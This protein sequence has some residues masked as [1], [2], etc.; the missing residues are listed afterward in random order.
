MTFPLYRRP[1]GVVFLDDD[2][3]YLEMLAMVMP[4]HW[5]LELFV[6]PQDCINRMQREPPLWEADA[7]LQQ[8]IVN[9]WREGQS[10]IPQLLAYWN[11]NPS[12]FGL[13]HV[14]VVDYSMPGLNGLQVLGELV[15]WP[16]TRVLLTGRA[17]E[18]IAVNA[19]NH[20]L[21]EQFIA[22]QTYDITRRLGEV[23]Q[24]LL[25]L[26]YARHSNIWRSTL[27]PEQDA[28]LR[29]PSVSRDLTQL[30]QDQG[31]IEHVV[32]GNPFGVLALNSS[33]AASWLQLERSDNLGEL[34]EL[35]ESQGVPAATVAQIRAGEKLVNMELKL[36]LQIEG[37]PDV[38]PAFAMGPDGLLTGALFAVAGGPVLDPQNNY[39]AFLA[40]YAER[41]VQD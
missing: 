19:F 32:I 20:G 16:G 4:Q 18:Q 38:S 35:A 26:P 33:G 7:W 12:R 14:C 3:A 17:D 11:D 22:K 36:A 15:D 2:P 6:R 21:I 29:N 37:P 34:A 24:R 30:C 28:Q 8:Q 1:G 39:D 41:S 5:R 9:R 40:R 25:D 27:T 31:W 13:T 23:V 10:L